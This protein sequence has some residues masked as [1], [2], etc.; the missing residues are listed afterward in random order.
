[1][2]TC[3]SSEALFTILLLGKAGVATNIGMIFAND[4]PGMAT[5]SFLTYIRIG[6][7]GVYNHGCYVKDR[8]YA[9]YMG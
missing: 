4:T 1:V 8:P 9:Y 5:S 2:N 7:D 3:A 6:W